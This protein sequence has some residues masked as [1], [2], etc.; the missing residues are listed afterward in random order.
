MAFTDDRMRAFAATEFLISARQF[1]NTAAHHSEVDPATARDLADIIEAMPLTV[2]S[3]AVAVPRI[4]GTLN[5][6][7]ALRLDIEDDASRTD[8]WLVLRFVRAA[9]R[10]VE[11]AKSVLFVAA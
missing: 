11:E 6:I 10:Q 5:D 8:G 4:R 7:A 3:P 2:T 9:E 1:L